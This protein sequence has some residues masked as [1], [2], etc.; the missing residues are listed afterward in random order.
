MLQKKPIIFC[1]FDGTITLRD[2]IMAIMRRFAP[3]GWESTADQI[4]SQEISIREGVERLFA[5]L[6]GSLEKEIIQFTL[7]QAEIRPGFERLLK[8]AEEQGLLFFVVS[9]G[10]DFF[11]DPLLAPFKLAQEQVFRNES[12][13][14]GDRIKIIWTHPCDE[15]CDVDCG[16][17]KVSIIR[18]YSSEDYFKIV[19]GDSITDL[20][21]AK[22]ADVVF[23]RGFLLEKCQEL[24]LRHYAYETF[25]DIVDVLRTE[26]WKADEQEEF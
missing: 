25:D 19:I 15:Q 21:G 17:C 20:A 9:G 11:I 22:L 4:Y 16:L 23:A 26:L 18:S 12:D 6:P 10:I 1:D 24:G 14:S 2:N 8:Y 3:K 5:M 13:F 7:E